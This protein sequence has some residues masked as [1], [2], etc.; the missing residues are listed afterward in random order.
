MASENQTLP[1]C[2]NQMEITH[3]KPLEPSM[4]GEWHERG[5]GTACYV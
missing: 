3:S 2:V 1:H 5:I 4:A